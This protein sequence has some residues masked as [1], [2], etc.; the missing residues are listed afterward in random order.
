MANSSV[1]EEADV[2]ET[3]INKKIL[4]VGAD[5]QLGS[6]LVKSL[7]CSEL[8]KPSLEEFDVA[9]FRQVADY[10]KNNKPDIVINTAAFHQVDDCEKNPARSFLLNTDAVKNL[11]IVCKE[12]GVTLVH[13]STDYV[14]GLDEKR[15]KPYSEDDIPEPVNVYG[16]SK[17]AGENFIRYGMEKYFIIRPAGLF[18]VAGA[19]GKGGNFVETM[20]RLGREKGLVKVKND[21]FTTPT[22]T[23]ELAENIAA[24]IKTDKYGLFHMTSQGQ[25]SWFDFAKK[26]FELTNEKVECLPISSL[27]LPTLARRPKYS[28]LENKRLKEIGLDLMSD[29]ETALKKYLEDKGYI[30]KTNNNNM[31]ETKKTKIDGLDVASLNVNFDDRGYL[32]EIVHNYDIPK[33]GQVYIVGDPVRGLIRAFHKHDVLWDYFCIVKGS[34]KFVFSD[35]RKDS[36]TY[37]QIETL[38]I[39]EKTPKMIIV[40]PGVYHGWMSLE[41]DTIMV[42]TG[43]EVYNKEKPDEYRISPDTFG[44]VWTIKGK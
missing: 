33:F 17:L 6:D 44:D 31:A 12:T 34:A 18:G 43:S 3:M 32:F 10:I 40:P 29:W 4:I 13:I 11:V 39:S 36:K 16:V 2:I 22:S 21:E 28:V 37:K 35:D 9:N 41:D 7:I 42:S 1:G 8:L 30:S 25:C 23:R 24:L 5:G 26:I 14:F 19:K 15:N 38:V 27:E 20:L